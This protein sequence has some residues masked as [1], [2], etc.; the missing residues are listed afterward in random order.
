[1]NKN[2]LLDNNNFINYKNIL[3]ILTASLFYVYGPQFETELPDTIRIIFSYGLP[4]FIIILFIVYLGDDNLQLSLFISI[5]IILI[6][7]MIDKHEIKSSYN[8]KY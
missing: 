2:I 8:K 4:K 6:V 1:M 3:L 7:S 5:L